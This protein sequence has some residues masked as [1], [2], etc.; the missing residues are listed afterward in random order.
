MA[1]TTRKYDL[2]SDDFYA[3]AYATFAQMREHDPV[4]CQ[5][6]LDGET[7]IWFVTSSKSGGVSPGKTSSARSWRSRTVG[8]RSPKRSSR[9]WSRC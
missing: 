3:N 5:P 4:F 2:Y 8:T 6:G 7:P 9:A 1:A